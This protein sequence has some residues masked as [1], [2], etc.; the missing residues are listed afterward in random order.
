MI[1]RIEDSLEAIDKLEE[2]LESFN[3]VTKVKRVV[4]PEARHPVAAV[5]SRPMSLIATS[6][7][8]STNKKA[9]SVQ[10]T[11]AK[12]KTTYSSSGSSRFSTLNPAKLQVAKRTLLNFEL[13]DKTP[14]LRRISLVRTS[15]LSEPKVKTMKPL[16]IPSLE[17]ASATIAR[18]LKEQRDAC[19]QKSADK[20]L[21]TTASGS[22]PG[23]G[24]V[25][26]TKPPTHPNF[27]L[28]SDAIG[29]R[30]R[31]DREASPKAKEEE[32]RKKR[33]AKT[34]PIRSSTTHT[35]PRETI[36]SRARQQNKATPLNTSRHHV[37]P[38]TTPSKRLS[39]TARTP[40]SNSTASS[41]SPRGRASVTSSSPTTL[42]SRA[43]SAST[44]SISG[45]RSIVSA[46]DHQHQKM[47]GK[48][49]YARDNKYSEDRERE[50]RERELN[51]KAARQE[52]AER[53]RQASREWAEKQ[54]QK[55]LSSV[56]AKTC[57]ASRHIVTS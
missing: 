10:P 48:E 3:A 37:Q 5:R 28:L 29:W 51:A 41:V 23:L 40:L 4:S 32:E 22:S 16:T 46:D 15:S 18:K 14:A 45:K 38:E 42:T 49:V 21:K 54:R 53:S 47:R 52:A 39:V 25:K 24:R 19:H 20:G 12:E 56:N 8:T 27:D 36:A 13:D 7:C 31:E 55:K 33:E 2:Q 34:K 9:S 6:P 44:G 57:S 1:S 30:K 11:P 17:L 35:Y 43:A 26:S 50:R